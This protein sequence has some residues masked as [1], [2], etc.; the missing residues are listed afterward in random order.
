MRVAL[1]RSAR[2]RKTCVACALRALSREKTT[3]GSTMRMLA[4]RLLCACLTLAVGKESREGGWAKALALSRAAGPC[5]GEG[6]GLAVDVG[7]RGG[8]ETLLALAYGYNVIAVECSLDAYGSMKQQFSKTGKKAA[9]GDRVDLRYGCA[10]DKPGT[11]QLNLAHDSSSVSKRAVSGDLQLKKAL[12]EQKMHN[13]SVRTVPAI[14]LDTLLPEQKKLCAVKVDSQ[15]HEEAVF[16]GMANALARD[17]PVLYFEYD[18]SFLPLD[19]KSYLPWL[20]KLGYTCTPPTCLACNILCTPKRR[21]YDKVCYRLDG[22]SPESTVTPREMKLSDEVNRLRRV[23][24]GIR[25]AH[26]DVSVSQPQPPQQV[27]VGKQDSTWVAFFYGM[28]GLCV[29]AF[30]GPLLLKRTI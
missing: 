9:Y 25:H 4:L 19:R 20:H 28:A 23:T 17:L 29:G 2:V 3:R 1:S 18:T 8:G 24:K 15:G 5:E 27:D 6:D 30:V 21:S 16:H 14:V 13:E 10:H 11:L 22:A 7:A 12:K 26:A